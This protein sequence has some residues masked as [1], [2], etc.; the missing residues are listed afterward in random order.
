MQMA[1]VLDHPDTSGS[2]PAWLRSGRAFL[3]TATLCDFDEQ[4][5]PPRL[6]GLISLSHG[7]VDYFI[8]YPVADLLAKVA[9]QCLGVFNVTF[10]V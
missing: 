1:R 8:R 5:L 3:V 4:P 6:D 9:Q 2:C 10:S 7:F